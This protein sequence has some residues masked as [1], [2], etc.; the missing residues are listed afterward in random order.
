MT[1]YVTF[2][3]PHQQQF[4]EFSIFV[5]FF[6]MVWFALNLWSRG[7]T[8]WFDLLVRSLGVTMWFVLLA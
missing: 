5:D 2:T 8:L 7:V 3:Q 1:E 4:N 6:Q